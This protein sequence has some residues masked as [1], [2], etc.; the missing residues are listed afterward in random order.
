M[1]SR[2]DLFRLAADRQLI[3]DPA[4]W[5]LCHK[6]RNE[7]GHTYNEKLAAETYLVAKEFLNAAEELFLTLEGKHVG[8]E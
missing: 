3:S 1:F 2:R 5:F 7:T 8:P 6:V 4:P